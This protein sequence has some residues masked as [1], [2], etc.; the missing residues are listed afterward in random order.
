LNLGGGLVEEDLVDATDEGDVGSCVRCG[1][2]GDAID[3]ESSSIV[4]DAMI[5]DGDGDGDG[6]GVREE[7]DG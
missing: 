1:D 4:R 2:L 5:D 3:D 6:N 7:D